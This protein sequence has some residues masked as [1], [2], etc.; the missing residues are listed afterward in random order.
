MLKITMAT[1]LLTALLATAVSFAGRTAE[2]AFNTPDFT[3]GPVHEGGLSPRLDAV[4]PEETSDDEALWDELPCDAGE[5][6]FPDIR[7]GEGADGRQ[8]ALRTFVESPADGEAVWVFGADY[9]VR[10]VVNGKAELA[11]AWTPGGPM[12]PDTWTVRTPLRKGLNRVYAAVT[13]GSMAHAFQLKA[14]LPDG[15]KI[16]SRSR[17]IP[18]TSNRLSIAAFPDAR[19]AML[20]FSFDDGCADQYT[21]AA[22]ILEQYGFRGSFFVITDRV[23]DS[24]V[25]ARTAMSWEELRDL[26]SRG[27]EIGSHSL[28]HTPHCVLVDAKDHERIA[29]EIIGSAE[30]IGEQL[31]RRAT[32]FCFPGGPRGPA[33]PLS[34]EIANAAGIATDAGYRQPM[35]PDAL[36]KYLRLG[37]YTTVIAHDLAAEKQFKVFVEAV[38]AATNRVTVQ[39][40]HDGSAYIARRDACR[41][42][43]DPEASGDSA[44]YFLRARHPSPLFEAGP[45]TLVLDEPEPGV[46]IRVNGRPVAPRPDTTDGKHRLIFEARPGD[47]IAVFSTSNPQPSTLNPKP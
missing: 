24:N 20:T 21:V 27:H 44:L 45:L 36:P 42:E 1:H 18:A 8:R 33:M 29:A 12:R 32:S 34:I 3:A 39:T 22:P 25:A 19:A 7:L 37:S 2:H 13:S 17:E 5:L 46:V 28:D 38:A 31:G 40:F 16:V 23:A 4:W 30:L 9:G 47:C 26:H 14:T 41:L 43:R 15:C 35:L 6:S 10:F 11:G